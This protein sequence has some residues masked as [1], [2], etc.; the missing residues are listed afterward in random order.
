[1][2]ENKWQIKIDWLI[3]WRSPPASLSLK[4]QVTKRTTVNWTIPAL[5]IHPL[6][7]E[8]G[9][10]EGT[11]FGFQQSRSQSPQAFLSVVGRP[12]RLWGNRI[13]FLFFFRLAVPC[14]DLLF[15]ARNPGALQFHCPRVSPSLYHHTYSPRYQIMFAGNGGSS[16]SEVDQFKWHCRGTGSWFQLSKGHWL[17]T[18]AL[19]VMNF[20]QFPVISRMLIC[21]V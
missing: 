16:Q 11:Y 8:V 2:L 10:N 3:D 20:E 1:M 21:C 5:T 9:I 13:R 17:W 15:W 14:N 6:G 18:V 12:E 4:G 19:T 7:E